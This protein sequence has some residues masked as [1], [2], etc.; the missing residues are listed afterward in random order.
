M[1]YALR[2]LAA[3]AI[4]SASSA[5]AIA[6]GPGYCRD[7]AA[8][9]VIKA[10]ENRAFRCGY[11]GLRWGTNYAVHFTWCLNARRPDT[12]RERTAR[13]RMIIACHG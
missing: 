5:G 11:S 12:I 7:Y 8:A 3:S 2:A 13:R 9:A 1:S 10:D 6:E 4:L